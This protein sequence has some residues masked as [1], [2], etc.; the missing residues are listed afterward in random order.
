MTD[1]AFMRLVIE[2]AR[3]GVERGQTPF[4]A[5]LVKDEHVVSLHNA[6]WGV[7]DVTAHA[8]MQVIRAACK[9]LDARDLSGCVIYSTCAPCAMCFGA[10]HWARISR[11]IYGVSLE[12]SI[13]AGLGDLPVSP[14]TMKQLGNSPVEINGGVLVEE[15][16]ELFKL[17]AERNRL[18][19]R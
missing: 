6:A 19:R 14:E 2:E 10:C 13:G 5:C 15:N 11:I 4:G 18:P 16:R 12:D 7:N 8:E 1:E 3:H 9:E 17:W